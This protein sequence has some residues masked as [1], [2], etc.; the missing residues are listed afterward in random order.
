MT[1]YEAI[2]LAAAALYLW[3][4]MVLFDSFWSR[5]SHDFVA[6]AVVATIALFWL[7]YYALIGLSWLW[8]RAAK[9]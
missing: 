7:P 9:R 4:T 1:A 6:R 5:M 3:N 2:V 8:E